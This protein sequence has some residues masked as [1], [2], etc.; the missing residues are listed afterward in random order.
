MILYAKNIS[1]KYNGVQ[2][3]LA[4]DNISFKFEKGKIYGIFGESG[5]GKSTLI[6]LLS[7]ILSPTEGEVYFNDQLVSNQKDNVLCDFRAN[8]IGFVFQDFS[9]FEELTVRENIIFPLKIL[10]KEVDNVYIDNLITTLQLKD[11]VNSMPNQLSGGQQQR[12]AIARA[13]ANKPDVLFA[14]EPTGNLDV[15]NTN[16]VIDLFKDLQKEYQITMII[17]SHDLKFKRIADEIITLEDG[18]II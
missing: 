15:K 17:V 13:L 11:K 2:P 9:L 12:V 8:H 1:K 10:K 3:F 4:I 7:T 6:Y 5:S 16:N 18:K 14:D